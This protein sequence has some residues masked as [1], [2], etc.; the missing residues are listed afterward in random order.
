MNDATSEPRTCEICGTPLRRDNKSGICCRKDS[1][2]CLAERSRRAHAV[3]PLTAR[4][5]CEVCGGVLRSTNVTGLCRRNPECIEE[6]A[7]R[8]RKVRPQP[9][10]CAHPDGCPDDAKVHGYCGMHWQRL[11]DTGKLGPAGPKT[12]PIVVHAGDVFGKWTALEDYD[13]TDRKVLCRCECGTKRRVGAKALVDGASKSCQCRRGPRERRKVPVV[14]PGETYSCL[15]VLEAGYLYDDLVLVRCRE[16]RAEVKKAAGMVKAGKVKTCG[17]GRGSG[18]RT[19]G[20]YRHPLYGIWRGIIGRC[21]DPNNAAYP[22]YGG[23]IRRITVCEGWRGTPDGLLNFI[24]DMGLRPGMQYTVDRYPD[25]DGGYWCGR[26][27]E[28]VR[29]GHPA[30]CRWATK[31]EQSLNQRKVAA[32]TLE[33]AALAARLEEVQRLLAAPGRKRAAR[34]PAAQGVLF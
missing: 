30:N 6:R 24:E 11:R 8:R 21:T 22:K 34:M 3:G 16:C 33:R 23:D 9:K 10:P 18:K 1:P 2:A 28:C 31:R 17:C 4:R 29:S 32:L 5:F 14:Q 15:T 26:C 7:A 27:D 19:H 13:R 12:H 20:L 25:N